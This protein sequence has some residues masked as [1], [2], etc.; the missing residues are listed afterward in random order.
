MNLITCSEGKIKLD[1][2]LDI[3][4]HL[5]MFSQFKELKLN[6]TLTFSIDNKNEVRVNISQSYLDPSQSKVVLINKDFPTKQIEP[7]NNQNINET[8][9][10]AP[11][12]KN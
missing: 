8:A 10:Y 6:K 12:H 5:H 2:N 11:N 4:N 1:S 9:F 3:D 7:K